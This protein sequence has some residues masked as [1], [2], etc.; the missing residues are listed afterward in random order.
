MIVRQQGVNIVI[1][2]LL[3]VTPAP[4]ATV[5]AAVAAQATAA[6]PP[7]SWW[8]WLV[9]LL[10]CSLGVAWLL[11]RENVQP[12]SK[13]GETAA[14]APAQAGP[15]ATYER[16]TI[17]DRPAHNEQSTAPRAATVSTTPHEATRPAVSGTGAKTNGIGVADDLTAIEGIGPKIREVLQRADILTFSDLAGA[18]VGDLKQ[19]LLDAGLRVNNPATWPAQAALAAAGKWD[20]LKAMQVQLKA[21]RRN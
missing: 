1:N 9:L 12:A 14:S 21:G 13:P 20:D 17:E 3:M 16:T 8:L 6:A 18:D 11:H 2:V 10:L 19:I 5:L 15:A 4:V 7:G